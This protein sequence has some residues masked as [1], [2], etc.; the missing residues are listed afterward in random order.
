MQ[1]KK[2]EYKDFVYKTPSGRMR[3]NC[4]QHGYYDNLDLIPMKTAF[5][6][7]SI[8]GSFTFDQAKA[9]FWRELK[10]EINFELRKWL[11]QDWEP[12]DVIGPDCVAIRTFKSFNKGPIGTAFLILLSVVMLGLPILWRNTVAEPF[13]FRLTMRR[14]AKW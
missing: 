6:Q 4:G 7:R 8:K 3:V 9:L 13:E 2:W 12:G 1:S 10:D 14:P 11:D 5:S